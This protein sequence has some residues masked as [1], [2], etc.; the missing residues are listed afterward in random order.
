MGRKRNA[1][2][3]GITN[4]GHYTTNRRTKI[5]VVWPHYSKTTTSSN[6]VESGRDKKPEEEEEKGEERDI[7]NHGSMNLKSNMTRRLLKRKTFERHK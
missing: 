4:K 6:Q 3:R 5:K 1:K 2:V 7:W